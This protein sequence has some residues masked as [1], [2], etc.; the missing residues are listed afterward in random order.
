[1]VKV[2]YI[3]GSSRCGS[4]V[5]SNI[6]GELDGFFSGGEIRFLWDRVLQSRKCGC[7]RLVG[8]CDLWTSVLPKEGDSLGEKRI[9]TLRTSQHEVLRLH[10]TPKLLRLSPQRLL[11]S[12]PLSRYVGA[13]TSVYDGLAANTGARVIVDSS[14][15][16]SNAA[17]LRL[18]GGVDPYF[19]HLVRDPRGVAYSRRR[20]KSNPD[21]TGEMATDSVAFSAID[22]MA[23]N[24]VAERVTRRFKP[25]RTMFIR[26][27]D[28]VADPKPTTA[29][30]GLLLGEVVNRDPFVDARTVN[31]G[32]NHT[33]SGNA[34]R[35]RIGQVLLRP[36]VEWLR[37]MRATDRILTTVLTLPLL[38][39]YGYPVLPS[40]GD[41]MATDGSAIVTSSDARHEKHDDD[42][43]SHRV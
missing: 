22:W 8:Q 6:L 29:R 23:T 32:P 10:H 28:F 9:K 3:L 26:Y 19:I 20:P 35:F 15:R 4:T 34:D 5:L 16:P 37:K 14:K 42:G 21:G 27:E 33:V 30:I 43:E 41:S 18:I 24:L 39:R 31:L 11:R 36:D 7:Q 38:V 17:A 1:M 2:L 12:A 25:E 13:M 40:A